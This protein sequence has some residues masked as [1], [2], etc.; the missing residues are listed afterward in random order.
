MDKKPSQVVSGLIDGV[1]VLR[2]L[3]ASPEPVTGVSIA[4]ALDLSP[5]RVSRLLT[6]LSWMGV[7]YRDK[8]RRYA[9]GA[10]MHSLATQNLAASGLLRRVIKHTK[11]L[12][13]YPYIVAAGVLWRDQVTFLYYRNDNEPAIEG[14]R[15]WISPATKSSIGLALLAHR[16]DESILALY[17]DRTD[18]PGLYPRTDQL[19]Q[20][21]REIRE[22]GYAAV[23]W[24]THISL[25]VTVGH[26]P[27]TAL[28]VS[29]FETAA[30]ETHFL[31]MLR[32]IA[33]AV[34]TD[35]SREGW[36]DA[37]EQSNGDVGAQELEALPGG[38][39]V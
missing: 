37:G 11:P 35:H 4:R 39:Y 12:L 7:V 18:I 32:E 13:E 31:S 29:G 21:I 14:V 26:P 9:P 23:H 38:V 5:V 8:S 10:G 36:S 16:T 6:T 27:Y 34:E 30:E 33:H 22:S 15:Q 19:M 24:P 1:E 3:A 25:A 28:A 2:Y 17:G 20:A